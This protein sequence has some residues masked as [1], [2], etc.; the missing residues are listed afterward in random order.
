MD[1]RWWKAFHKHYGK[2]SKIDEYKTLCFINILWKSLIIFVNVGDLLYSAQQVCFDA[3]KLGCPISQELYNLLMNNFQGCTTPYLYEGTSENG[4]NLAMKVMQLDCCTERQFNDFCALL[5]FELLSSEELTLQTIKQ[6][7]EA[8]ILVQ[9]E[10]HL[11]KTAKRMQDRVTESDNT[12]TMV[13]MTASEMAS[14][15]KDIET[16]MENMFTDQRVSKQD[17]MDWHIKVIEARSE[18]VSNII[19]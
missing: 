11:T 13:F 8:N 12:N 14:V 1:I 16:M 19:E 10:C 4:F 2:E 15:K 18:M 6:I 5:D 7:K 3:E 17:I 9:K